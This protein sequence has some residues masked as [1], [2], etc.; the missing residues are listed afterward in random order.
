VIGDFEDETNHKLSLIIDNNDLSIIETDLH[1]ITWDVIEKI[2]IDHSIIVHH[3]S[4][5]RKTKKS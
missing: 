5:I 1:K 4:L 3:L 2:D